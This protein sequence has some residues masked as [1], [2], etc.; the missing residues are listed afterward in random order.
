VPG[1]LLGRIN[2]DPV[3][4]VLL[5]LVAAAHV[6]SIGSGR[7]RREA[8]AAGWLIA[9]VAL[10]SPLCALSVALFSARVGQH[11]IL[12]LVAAP[13]IALGAPTG[14]SRK[15]LLWPGTIAFFLALWFWHMPLAYDATLASTPIY[16]AMHLS[17][18]AS[19]ILLWTMLLGHSRDQA[20]AA[21]S[22]GMIT[23]VHMGLLGA[24]LTFSS[25]AWFAPHFATVQPWGF[26]PLSDQQLGG[27]LMWVPGCALF[28][29]VAL[30]SS[31]SL[32][33]A[34][35]PAQARRA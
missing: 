16:W 3:L 8:A 30:R 15:R 25:R 10:L 12:L 22:A 7:G 21:L 35:E 2:D 9:G 17:L 23:S 27:V 14:L 18:F 13:L 1:A 28:L 4:I 11:M 29:L 19:A 34:L 20:V 26:T 32:W 5:A 24:V 6:L 31:L 33:R